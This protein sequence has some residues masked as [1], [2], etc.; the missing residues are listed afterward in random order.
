MMKWF[1]RYFVPHLDNAYRPNF[2]LGQNMKQ[3]MGIVLGF[4]L[5][6]FVLPALNP[7]GFINSFNLGAVLPAVLSV[8][9]NEERLEMSL[10]I[11][12]ENPL[13][14]HIA[15]LKAE[16]MATKGYFAHTSPEGKTPWYWFALAGYQYV[17]AGENLAVN[18]SDSKDVTD[19]WMN[20]PTHRA[21]IVQGAYTEMGTG[22]ATGVYQGQETIFVAQVYAAP[23]QQTD[24]RSFSSQNPTRPDTDGNL[25]AVSPVESQEV[26]GEI[27]KEV[28]TVPT[29]PTFVEKT[30]SSPHQAA[31]VVSYVTLSIVLAALFLNIVIKFDQQHPDLITN[32]L[33]VAVIIFAVHL[34]NDYFVKRTI[35]TSF[36]A[37]SAEE[38][39]E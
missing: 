11:L 31:N 15:Q 36:I 39:P 18:F 5:L 23:A 17:Y 38:A 10:P 35:E 19:A 7:V 28:E 13:L 2:L 8:L 1:K 12:I 33:I 26:L 34:S 16:D 32:G 6:L 22:I 29:E 4:E 27:S 24:S 14:T 37:F 20:S 30:L 25:L 3:F 9:T 21:N